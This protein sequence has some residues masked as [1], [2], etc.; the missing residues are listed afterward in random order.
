MPEI[1]KPMVRCV[2][3]RAKVNPSEKVNEISEENEQPVTLDQS[4]EEK[5]HRKSG[6]S[7]GE[8]N[9]RWEWEK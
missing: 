1:A 9:E 4:S 3:H 5:Y 7:I 8:W 6:K 2:N